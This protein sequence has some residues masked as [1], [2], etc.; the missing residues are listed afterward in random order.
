MKNT[1]YFDE[2]EWKIEVNY[3]GYKYTYPIYNMRSICEK[4]GGNY[5][6]DRVNDELMD[7][8]EDIINQQKIKYEEINWDNFDYIVYDENNEDVDILINNNL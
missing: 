3:S 8:V 1:N 7:C 5:L 6:T 2:G 4:Y